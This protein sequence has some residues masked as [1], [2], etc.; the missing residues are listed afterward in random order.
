ME[1]AEG[2]ERRATA[3][4]KGKAVEIPV[5]QNFVARVLDES[6]RR[7]TCLALKAA[8]KALAPFQEVYMDWVVSDTPSSGTQPSGYPFKAELD[9]SSL[10]RH[11]MNLIFATCGLADALVQRGFCVEAIRLLTEVA[12]W[13]PEARIV[14]ERLGDLP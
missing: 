10:L 11:R 9:G 4:A 5:E 3:G 2:H 1:L 6:A 13:E 8:M 7:A 12:M 14:T